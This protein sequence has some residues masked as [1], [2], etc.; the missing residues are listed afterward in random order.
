MESDPS[1]GNFLAGQYVALPIPSSV[2]REWEL[3]GN[4]DEFFAEAEMEFAQMRGYQF[5]WGQIVEDLREPADSGND[6]DADLFGAHWGFVL[7][8]L[9][10]AF[11]D[12]G[13]NLGE[14]SDLAVDMIEDIRWDALVD[15]PPDRRPEGLPEYIVFSEGDNS[16]A[17]D[18]GVLGAK[19]VECAR[20]WVDRF[21]IYGMLPILIERLRP[22]DHRTCID[23]G[24]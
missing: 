22:S 16:S 21:V 7:T 4:D 12:V 14:L 8:D 11:L 20:Q 10:D 1:N 15:L 9:H 5:E 19:N 24:S 17:F 6:P 3:N 18:I 2:R 23:A 13:G